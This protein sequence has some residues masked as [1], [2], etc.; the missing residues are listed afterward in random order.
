MSETL[1]WVLI[2]TLVTATAAGICCCVA[3]FIT[4]KD[5]YMTA[6]FLCLLVAHVVLVVSWLLLK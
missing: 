2:A 5:R 1:A 6:G 4:K 3:E